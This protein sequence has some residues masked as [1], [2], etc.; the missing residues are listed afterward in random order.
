MS[1]MGGVPSVSLEKNFR[2]KTLRAQPSL[3]AST[4]SKWGLERS[5]PSS[6]LRL[7]DALSTSS[8][9]LFFQ[10]HILSNGF[11][12]LSKCKNWRAAAKMRGRRAM[13]WG[14]PSSFSTVKKR[15]STSILRGPRPPK[16]DILARALQIQSP[17]AHCKKHARFIHKAF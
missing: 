16:I 1:D 5:C 7:T 2:G 8:L 9:V 12:A 3:L 11:N 15:R 4:V 13:F 14:I 10:N 17:K 6:S